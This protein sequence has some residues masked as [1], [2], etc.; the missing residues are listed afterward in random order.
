[1]KN[2]GP[3]IAVWLSVG[4]KRPTRLSGRRHAYF[5]SKYDSFVPNKTQMKF[6]KFVLGVHKSATNIA[7]LSE[8]GLFPLSLCTIKATINYW[9]HLLSSN[10]NSLIY[11]SYQENT[12][13]KDGL[14]SKIKLFLAEIGFTYAWV[15]QGTFSKPKLLH[16]LSIKLEDRYINHW[17]TLLFNGDNKNG[18]DKLRTYRK[19]K[20]SYMMEKFVHSDVDKFALSIFVKIRIS[21]SNLNIERGRYIKLLVEK[22]ICPLCNIEPEDEIHFILKCPKLDECRKELFSN[23]RSVVP[24]FIDM[25]EFKKFKFILSSNDFDICKICILGVNKLYSINQDLKVK[26]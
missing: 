2:I 15:N 21:N 26:L 23:I 10:T 14:C 13:R 3:E 25:D 5:E 22:R 12:L 11:H 1:M 6:A 7:V 24:S 9:L 8:L 16:S 20:N 17:K 18:G 4:V 19:L